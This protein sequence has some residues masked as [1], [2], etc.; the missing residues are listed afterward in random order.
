MTT[1]GSPDPSGPSLPVGSGPGQT[2]R[3]SLMIDCHGIQLRLLEW[4][5]DKGGIPVVLLHGLASNARIWELV[6]PKLVEA[7]LRPLAP[8][9]RGHG[10][11]D[12][13][14]DGYTAQDM[15]GD[16]LALMQQLDLQ[17]PIIA[18]HSWGA[19]IALVLGLL[20]RNGPQA[21]Q[22]LVLVDGGVVQ[23]DDRPGASWELVRRELEPP[24]LAGISK[25]EFLS[26]LQ[27][28]DRPWHPGTQAADIILANFAQDADGSLSPHLSYEHHM[29]V[30][31]SIWEFKTYR[32]FEQL[33]IPV[34]LLPAEPPETDDERAKAFLERKR[35]G[36]G[37]IL[38]RNSQVRV[39]WMAQSVHDIPL[40]RPDQLAE[41][42]IEFGR[43][44][45]SG[46]AEATG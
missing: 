34:L 22:G 15:A 20:A 24:R 29:Q 27:A 18:G 2:A 17:H 35:H 41:A 33:A 21:P 40:Q 16:V 32:Y 8:D 6:A 19:S 13:P 46:D 43:P 38:R 37:Q 26:R 4:D 10:L 5:G 42:L 23:A 44:W 28:A 7:G 39:R 45:L 3:R 30:V 25:Q 12:K 31:R 11:S 1:T 14:Q 9:L 36:I